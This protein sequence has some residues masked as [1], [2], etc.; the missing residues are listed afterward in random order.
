MTTPIR[1]NVRTPHRTAPLRGVRMRAE[2]DAVSVR[3]P[4]GVRADVRMN[5]SC[6]GAIPITAARALGPARPRTHRAPLA[7]PPL[8]LLPALALAGPLMPARAWVSLGLQ[9]EKHPCKTAAWKGARISC[10]DRR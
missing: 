2:R 5:P 8:W 3:S 9:T 1:E 6:P 7:P 10:S 4:C